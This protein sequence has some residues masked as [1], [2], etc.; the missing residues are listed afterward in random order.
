MARYN[1][2][3]PFVLTESKDN[4]EVLLFDFD[5]FYDSFEKFGYSG[6][7][8]SWG[9]LVSFILKKDDPALL[10]R[11][12]LDPEGDTFVAIT[13]SLDDQKRLGRMLSAIA[14]DLDKLEQYLE[15][16]PA[17]EMED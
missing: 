9:S 10:S 5:D 2:Y 6:N 4:F 16:V 3:E 17:D 13:Y 8:H 12:D 1:P 15:A 14:N 11:I 7:G